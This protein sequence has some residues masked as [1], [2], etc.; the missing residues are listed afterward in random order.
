[1]NNL[2]CGN[3]S[4]VCSVTMK[5]ADESDQFASLAKTRTPS[6]AAEETM[7]RFSKFH[8]DGRA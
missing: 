2:Y 6:T 8:L 7:E 4:P 1:V 3:F 5:A